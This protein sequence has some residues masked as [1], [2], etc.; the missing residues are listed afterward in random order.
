M[1]DY[2]SNY[3]NRDS[4]NLVRLL[5][6]AKPYIWHLLLCILMLTVIVTSDLAQ[7]VI[8]GAAVDD[9]INHYDKQYV[10]AAQNEEAEYEVQGMR[11]NSIDDVETLT[12]EGPYTIM[13]YIKNEYYLIHDL[14]GA[15]AEELL[16]MK[17][18]E[19]N[20]VVDGDKITLQDGSKVSRTLLEKEDL[21][22][23]RSK[24]YS[25][26]TKLAIIYIVLLV[27]GLLTSFAQ[28]ILLGY[29]GQKIIYT[30]RNQLYQHVES[31]N[32]QFF[33]DTPVGKL[34]TRLTNDTEG[35][36]ELCTN[37]IVTTIKCIFT[38]GG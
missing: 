36:N 19:D 37:C 8:I 5:S 4:K 33:N 31:L 30:I 29:V 21:K 18:N 23:L 26:L 3:N 2:E 22:S 34:V 6:Y 28:H 14:T 16:A 10:T 1:R 38:L 35:V 9:L 27:V 24:D 11:L 25:E 7:P 20:L 17:G 12:G 32:I 15:Q 13:L